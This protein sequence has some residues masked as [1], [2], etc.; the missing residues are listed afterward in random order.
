V[1]RHRDRDRLE[2]AGWHIDNEPGD[3]A[4]ANAVEFM[5]DCPNMPVSAETLRRL[6][7][8]THLCSKLSK[9]LR[10]NR[11]DSLLGVLCILGHV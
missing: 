6:R 1:Q 7:C 3:L 8:S 11:I 2:V 5:S 4:A 9:S 10:R